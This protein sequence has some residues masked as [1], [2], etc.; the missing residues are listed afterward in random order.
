MHALSYGTSS[1]SKS[2]LPHFNALKAL[3]YFGT[4]YVTSLFASFCFLIAH[5]DLSSAVELN[6]SSSAEHFCVKV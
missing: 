6:S 1:L 2:F 5:S 4:S 3:K